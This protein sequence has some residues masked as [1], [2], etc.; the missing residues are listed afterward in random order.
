MATKPKSTPT[1][2]QRIAPLRLGDSINVMAPDG[3]RLVNNE[4]RGHFEPG[5]PTPQT[6]TVTTLRRLADGDLVFVD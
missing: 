2:T 6:V 4:S 1:H 3:V 5:V